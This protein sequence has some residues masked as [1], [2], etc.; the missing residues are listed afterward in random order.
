M[1]SFDDRDGFAEEHRESP[2]FWQRMRRQWRACV[3]HV[4]PRY[5]SLY[6]ECQRIIQEYPE[7]KLRSIFFGVYEEN[8]NGPFTDDRGRRSQY[9]HLAV[10][11]K[12]FWQE[13]AALLMTGRRHLAEIDGA[14]PGSMAYDCITKSGL[15]AAPDYDGYLAVRDPAELNAY[16]ERSLDLRG[17]ADSG[18]RVFRDLAYVLCGRSYERLSALLRRI[19]RANAFHTVEIRD[20][21]LFQELGRSLGGSQLIGLMMF[22]SARTDV[23]REEIEAVALPLRRLFY[24]AHLMRTRAREALRVS[25]DIFLNLTKLLPLPQLVH[26]GQR[27]LY[28]NPRGLEFFGVKTVEEL[29]ADRRVLEYVHPA[30]RARVQVRMRSLLNDPMGRILPLREEQFL[31]IDGSTAD[32]EVAAAKVNWFGHDAIQVV[33]SDIGERKRVEEERERSRLYDSLTGLANRSLFLDRLDQAVARAARRPE[34]AAMDT[35]TNVGGMIATLYIDIDNFRE[36][37][38]LF[39]FPAGDELLRAIAD[40]MQQFVP[41]AF[42][43]SRLS[44]D[45]FGVF[46]PGIHD[47]A[48]AVFFA[49]GLQDLFRLKPFEVGGEE[50]PVTFSAGLAFYPMDGRSAGELLSHAEIALAR[51]KLHKNHVQLFNAEMN[52]R[53]ARLFETEK[54]LIRAMG[55]GDEDGESPDGRFVLYYQ[56][57]IDVE[58]R[59]VRGVEALIRWMHPVHGLIPPGEFID[60]AEERGLILE[61]GEWVLEEACRCLQAAGE[62][63]H[64]PVELSVNVTPRQLV[65]P[66]FAAMVQRIVRRTGFDAGRLKLEIVER[67]IV[68]DDDAAPVLRVMRE[69]TAVGIRFHVDDFGVGGAALT[70]VR[71]FPI[72]TIKIDRSFVENINEDERIVR[73]LVA[74]AENLGF[75][76]IVE[77]VETD[78][79]LEFFRSLGC[80]YYQGY[81][82]A[83]PMVAEE[84]EK[85]VMG[86]E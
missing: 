18:R 81:L 48:Q 47:T 20:T 13:R 4:E 57:Q 70:Y 41:Q 22:V 71:R 30:Y 26:D 21:D 56:P 61:I 36:I 23:S 6:F 50:I 3:S 64:P 33:F 85:F 80:R 83:K 7:L 40:R 86:F 25:D 38:D 17:Y 35:A 73:G 72:D 67:G 34:V 62:T 51:A 42:T 11:V 54:A 5:E 55:R 9:R 76:V 8:P 10:A 32:V 78:E 1:A 77:G 12:W 79:Q 37:N 27:I 74:F 44:G 15:A 59:T 19:N 31:R 39:R 68:G 28:M 53:T 45:K 43:L 75:D 24:D 58:D 2:G 66:D 82:F 65:H 49:E 63:A 14:Q 69:L 84:C 46:L 52:R 60:L 16:V 29:N